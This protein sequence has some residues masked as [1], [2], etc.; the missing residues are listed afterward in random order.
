MIKSRTV[1]IDSFKENRLQNYPLWAIREFVMNAV[2]HR[3]YESNAPTLIYDFNNRI[4]IIN[5][6]GLFG[7]ARPVNFPDASDYRNPAIAE[8]M[9]ILGYVN[10]FNFGVSNAQKELISNGN[11]EATFKLDLTT[12]FQVSIPINSTW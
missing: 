12:K 8:A 3:D 4:E 1:P 9:K 5:S 11:A 7:E 6:G 10:K 2:M